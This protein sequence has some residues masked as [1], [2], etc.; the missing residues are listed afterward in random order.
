M[1]RLQPA[2]QVRSFRDLLVWQQSMD[3]VE[4]TYRVT[5][6]FPHTERFGLVTQLRRAAVSV[7]SNI[8]EGH[9][10]STGDY[11]RLLLV[12]NGSLAEMET[13]FIVSNRLGFLG[14]S[15]AESLLK[16]CD[17]LGRMLGALRKSLRS[18][19]SRSP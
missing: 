10:R 7:A 11:L 17:Q 8:A 1:S 13:Q 12:S 18:R 9:A 6:N 14:D 15:D 16:T 3:L 5:N 19:L 4:T 2:S